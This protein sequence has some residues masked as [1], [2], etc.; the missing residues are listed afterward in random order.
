MLSLFRFHY[1]YSVI[2]ST[3]ILLILYIYNRSKVT[4][5]KLEE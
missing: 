5:E 1:L 4:I 2:S 3:Y